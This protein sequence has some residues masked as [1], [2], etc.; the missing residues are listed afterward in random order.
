MKCWFYELLIGVTCTRR[1]PG[2]QPSKI[3]ERRSVSPHPHVGHGSWRD[4]GCHNPSV[5]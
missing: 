2:S 1:N 3:A 5:W 4:F